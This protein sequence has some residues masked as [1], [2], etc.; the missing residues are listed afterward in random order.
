M[1]VHRFDRPHEPRALSLPAGRGRELTRAL[2]QLVADLR[3]AIPTAFESREFATK[4]SGLQAEFQARHEALFSELERQ[5]AAR[6]VAVLRSA[7][8]V[9]FAPVRDGEVLSP[10][11]FEKLPEAEKLSL[12]E[13]VRELERELGERAKELPRLHKELRDRV[14]ELE[15][16]VTRYATD[17]AVSELRGRWSTEPGVLAHLDALV[18]DVVEHGA[19]LRR[20]EKDDTA[21]ALGLRTERRFERYRANLLVAHADSRS[22]PVVYDDQGTYERL[23]GRIEH[24]AE[25][26]NLV[27]SFTLIK[28][29]SLH[30]ASGGFLLVDARRVLSNPQ[31]WD[32]LKRALFSRSIRIEPLTQLLGLSSGQSL[33]PEAI[34]L[35]VKVVL[36]G[37]HELYS[38]L[39]DAAPD[40]LELFK[41]QAN[42]EDAIAR[43]PETERALAHL[44]A[45]VAASRELLPLE[46]AAVARVVE[47]SSRLAAD[48]R[49]LSTNTRRLLTLVDEAEA[50]ARERRG[51]AVVLADVD[52]AIALRERRAGRIRERVIETISRRTVLIDT[53]GARVGQ[54]N[55]LAALSLGDTV[56]GRPTRITATARIGDGRVIDI[57]R[58]VELGGP[59]HSKGVLILSNYLAERHAKRSPLSLSASLVFEQSYGGVEGDSAALAELCALLS[60]LAEVPIAQSVAVTGS[61]T[62]WGEV[63]AIGAVNE[64]I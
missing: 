17:T 43:G 61:V 9:A 64:K 63:Q 44:L 2:D 36:F 14:R 7:A 25:F 15:R 20:E 24:V 27:T 33:R 51:S 12:R 18:E 38:L 37:P 58:E 34:P 35:D 23:L 42:F 30:R 40:F 31:A 47:E 21:L 55:G 11:E 19:E 8:G 32:G 22:A 10:D 49:K 54:V 16:A 50:L 26:G 57:E 53:A 60:A 46:A 4:L 1:Y 5:G 29:G 28:S 39:A 13:A 62:Q 48:S 6:G 3:A 56:F 41:V 52:R 45:G 59:L